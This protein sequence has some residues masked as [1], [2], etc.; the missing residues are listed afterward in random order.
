VAGATVRVLDGPDAGRTAQ[1]DGS[2]NYRFD[3]LAFGGHNFVA[4]ANGYTEDRR[5]VD[6]NG[7][8]AL[9]FTLGAPLWTASGTGADVFQ[10]PTFVRR[11]QI[12]GR[13]SGR[14]ENFIVRVGGRLVVNEIL[15]TCSVAT[16]GPN[17]SGVYAVSG[18]TV[19]VSSSTGIE[20][21]FDELR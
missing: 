16:A 18:G 5:G 13:Y 6:V 15:G 1:A 11:V 8:N 12:A 3:S 17:F 21:R 7:T 2:G 10:M 4:T 20:W 14:C 19:E 9:N